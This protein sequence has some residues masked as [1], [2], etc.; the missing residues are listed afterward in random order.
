MRVFGFEPKIFEFQFF[1]HF[2][3]SFPKKRRNIVFRSDDCLFISNELLFIF[4]IFYLVLHNG[5][6]R[7]ALRDVGRAG[8]R[9]LGLAF[10]VC[11]CRFP[12][13][14]FR[15]A[16]GSPSADHHSPLHFENNPP[17][18]ST[19]IIFVHGNPLGNHLR[20]HSLRVQSLFKQKFSV[21]RQRLCLNLSTKTARLN[22]FFLYTR[23]HS[24]HLTNA[25]CVFRSIAVWSHDDSTSQQTCTHSI[26][27][28]RFP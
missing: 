22:F 16:S 2:F 10:G 27:A 17:L 26:T 4:A 6:G 23:V 9:F 20:M 21:A 18:N 28:K 13:G 24:P 8:G 11:D 7:C 3:F 1:S 19:G 14:S 25:F 5:C 15:S 12:C